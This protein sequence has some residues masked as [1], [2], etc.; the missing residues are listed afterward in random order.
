[1]KLL[2]SNNIN[3]K[4]DEITYPFP[5]FN[6]EVEVWEWISMSNH[7]LLDMWLLIHAWIKINS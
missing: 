6:S 2:I 1:M 3:Y 4:V 7:T 5:N